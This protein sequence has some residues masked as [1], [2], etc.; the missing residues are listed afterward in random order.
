MKN[1]ELV[2]EI[3]LLIGKILYLII[4]IVGMVLLFKNSL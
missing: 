1:K 2:K 4:L 3:L